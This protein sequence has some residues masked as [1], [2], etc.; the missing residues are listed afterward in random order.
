MNGDPASRTSW[1]A[2]FRSLPPVV[3]AIT[4]V[5]T[6]ISTALALLFALVPGLRPG[7][8]SPGTPVRPITGGLEYLGLQRNVEYGVHLAAD[9]LNDPN[10][11]QRQLDRVGHVV[12]VSAA[13][14]GL[15]GRQVPLV[16]SI[17]HVS[18]SNKRPVSDRRY[19]NQ[20]PSQFSWRPANSSESSMCGFP[21][22][23]VQASM[24]RA[25]CSYTRTLR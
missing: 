15:D 19:L 23:R 14:G 10:A 13:L 18:G 21:F 5:L 20:P 24:S 25:S 11:D 17:Y 1:V 3:Q 12:E 8:G 16:W 9:R 6:L 4:G 7:D 2:R 22:H